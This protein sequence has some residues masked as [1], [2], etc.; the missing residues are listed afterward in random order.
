MELERF[1][2][3]LTEP[4]LSGRIRTRQIPALT[5]I[6]IMDIKNKEGKILAQSLRGQH[7]LRPFNF[8]INKAVAIPLS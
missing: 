6:R 4:L 5:K 1:N 7:D 3:S 2:K 8:P